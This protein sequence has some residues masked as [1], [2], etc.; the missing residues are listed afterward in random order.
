VGIDTYSCGYQAGPKE[1]RI[2]CF[3]KN[4]KQ[5]SDNLPAYDS[6]LR[7]IPKNPPFHNSSDS[8]KSLDAATSL[9]LLGIM[10]VV[11]FLTYRKK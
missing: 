5:L 6:K 8:E 11:S 4:H 7:N 10:A 3:G 9:L 2:C 1:Y